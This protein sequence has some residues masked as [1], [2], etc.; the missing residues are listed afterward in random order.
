MSEMRRGELGASL[1]IRQMCLELS[2]SLPSCT[3][4][5]VYVACTPTT[6]SDPRRKQAMMLGRRRDLDASSRQQSLSLFAAPQAGLK[7]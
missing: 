2:N 5:Q 1:C 6:D 4:V 3:E 7:V